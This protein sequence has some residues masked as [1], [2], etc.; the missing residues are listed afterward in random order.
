[1]GGVRG[2]GRLGGIGR[3][4]GA[5]LAGHLLDGPQDVGDL[6]EPVVEHSLRPRLAR[7]DEA[8]EDVLLAGGDRVPQVR[9]PPRGG[10]GSFR[11][12]SEGHRPTV[13]GAARGAAELPTGPGRPVAIVAGVTSAA[14][15]AVD[16]AA[17]LVAVDSVNPGLVPGAAGERAAVDLVR[18]RLADSSTALALEVVH[19]DGH[20]DRPSLLAWTAEPR[21]FTVLLTG[22]LDT[23]GVDGM[24]D[25]FA[26]TVD[27]DRLLGRGSCDMKRGAAALVTTVE[28]L[29]AD[30]A[31][32]RLVL[33]LV[34]D[35]E[36]ASLGTEAVLAA[37]PGL[38]LAPDVALVAE[39]TWLDLATSHRGY[40]VVE[41][42]LTGRASHSSQPE[43]GVNTAHAAARLVAAVESAAG[44][45]EARG[46]ALMVTVLDAGSAPFTVPARARV[47]VERRTVPGERAADTLAEVER[48]VAP[49]VDTL[50]GLTATARLTHAREA[51]LLDTEGPAARLA[52]ALRAELGARGQ[53]PGRLDAP[54][55]MESALWQEA[56]IPTVVCGPGGG[57]LHAVDEWLDLDQLRRFADALPA[58]VLRLA[59]E[60]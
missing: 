2:V 30:P 22:H 12:G 49:V 11:V 18:A 34:A 42:T 20:P 57:G 43:L 7:D 51:W 16:L 9:Q 4:D 28:A 59:A 41:V 44:D 32:P 3:Q 31:A 50:P 27:G 48:L 45:V 33:A 8:R 53:E 26:A 40:A 1:M 60:A 36:D 19:P 52:D 10:P 46:G 15:P 56:G 25:P 24:P 5:H 23:V 38:G 39:P 21:P 13:A 17:R 6:V 58:A 14:H 54:Y 37:L 55:W 29:A 47:V 35:E